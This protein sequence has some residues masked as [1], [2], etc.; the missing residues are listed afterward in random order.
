MLLYLY[1]PLNGL[2]IIYLQYN[3]RIELFPPV[4]ENIII[5]VYMVHMH[6]YYIVELIVFYQK[7]RLKWNP[8]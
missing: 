4:P 8:K 2:V 1:I 7:M 3:T 6:I 5:T